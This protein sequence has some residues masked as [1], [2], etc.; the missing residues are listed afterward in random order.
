MVYKLV[1]TKDLENLQLTDESIKSTLYYYV[2]ALAREYSDRGMNGGYVL[3][4]PPNTSAEDIKAYFD[5]TRCRVEYVEREGD[6]C[7]AM[8]LL[9]NDDAIVI[10]MS[11]VDIP[12]E[13]VKEIET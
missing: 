10:I 6:M 5:Y 8:Y 7:I 9:N 2:G 11:A 12:E 13:I 4:A 3:Y 1:N